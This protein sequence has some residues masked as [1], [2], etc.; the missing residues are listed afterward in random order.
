MRRFLRKGAKIFVVDSLSGGKPSWR[1]KSS[2][3]ASCNNE[4]SKLKNYHNSGKLSGTTMR[5]EKCKQRPSNR[6]PIVSRH[7]SVSG[8]PCWKWLWNRNIWRAHWSCQG[9]IS[10]CYAML[11]SQHH[12]TPVKLNSVIDY[13][14]PS[15]FKFILHPLMILKHLKL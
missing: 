13:I 11:C 5:M 8:E 7:L 10:S 15:Y 2:K 9:R 14:Y 12:S 1:G 3:G 6:R 4:F